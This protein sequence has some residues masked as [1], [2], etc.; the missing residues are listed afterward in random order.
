MHKAAITTRAY[1]AGGGIE[2]S[3]SDQIYLEMKA[4]IGCLKCI[5]WL[6]KNEI[7]HTTT[8][9]NLLQLAEELGCEYFKSLRVGHNATYTSRQVIDEFLGIMNDMIQESVLQSFRDSTY[10]SLMVDESTDISILKQLVLY[11]RA[12]VKGKLKSCFLK[13]VNLEDGKALTITNAITSYLE[14]A[15]LSTDRMSSFG[16]DGASVMVGGRSGVATQLRACNEQMIYIS[17]LCVP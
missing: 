11:G 17:S 8:Y 12:V 3:F 2:K 10:F 1:A 4:V 7:A 15:G 6:C 9:P 16:S 13:I 14:T 5:Y